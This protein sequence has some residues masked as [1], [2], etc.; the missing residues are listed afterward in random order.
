[1]RDFAAFT[2]DD[3][4]EKSTKVLVDRIELAEAGSLI[5]VRVLGSHFLWKMV[6]RI[7]GVLAGVGRGDISA[8]DAQRLLEG[9]EVKGIDATPASLTAPAA[10]LFLE[11]VYYDGD[12][13][14]PPLGPM[15]AVE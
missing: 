8:V 1:M 11:A 3:P 10:G 15:I 6:R 13:G 4:R 7:V 2:D 12:P 14:P 9:R 5:L